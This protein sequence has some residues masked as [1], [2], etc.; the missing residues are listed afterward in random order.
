LLDISVSRQLRDFRLSLDLTV[1]PG[2]YLILTGDNGA[3]K[4]TLL[5]IVAGL[6]TP[7]HG[8]ILLNGTTLFDAGKR[9]NIPPEERR[10]G[11]IF[12]NAAI[13]PHL[14]VTENIE[15][16]LKAMGM[17][18]PLR[19]KKVKRLTGQ[20]KLD[21]L[22]DYKAD[23]LSG[24]QKQLV[25]LGRAM[26]IDPVLLLLDEPYRALD[27]TVYVVVKECIHDVVRSMNIPCILVTHQVSDQDLANSRTCRIHEG[28]LV[29]S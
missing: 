28:K 2:E 11:Y 5:N 29:E 12:Q 19:E 17:S 26:A 1:K 6:M 20:L 4:S 10:I 15:Y 24:G 22:R 18:K 27:S 9:I 23:Q 13:F 7:D 25:A 16:G 21:N 8:S 3:G 14:T